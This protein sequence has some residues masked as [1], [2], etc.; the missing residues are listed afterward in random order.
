M[1]Q[2]VMTTQPSRNHRVTLNAAIYPEN[3][4]ILCAV[5]H[6][7]LRTQVMAGIRPHLEKAKVKCS[8]NTLFI[9][10]LL[11]STTKHSIV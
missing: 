1:E 6:K 2:K 4:T 9:V 7:K 3:H 8:L 10:H 5:K 11:I